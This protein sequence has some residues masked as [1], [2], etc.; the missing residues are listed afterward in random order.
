[1]IESPTFVLTSWSHFF[2]FLRMQHLQEES[3][4]APLHGVRVGKG[5]YLVI[6]SMKLYVF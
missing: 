3:D 1:M 4:A 6:H 2:V 5:F